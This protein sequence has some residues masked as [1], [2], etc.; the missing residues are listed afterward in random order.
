M[1]SS[2]QNDYIKSVKGFFLSATR[3]DNGND[4]ATINDKSSAMFNLHIGR[5]T[6]LFNDVISRHE[7]IITYISCE[8]FKVIN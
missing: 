7:N 6:S 8:S 1:F 3:L 4:V 2:E 5:L